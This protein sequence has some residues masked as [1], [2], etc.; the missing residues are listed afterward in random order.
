MVKFIAFMEYLVDVTGT[1]PSTSP[2]LSQFKSFRM[3]KNMH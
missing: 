2:L 3:E 1:T